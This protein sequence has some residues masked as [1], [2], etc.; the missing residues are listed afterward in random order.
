MAP[1]S[2]GSRAG[3]FFPLAL[4]FPVPV[5]SHFF[6]A[7]SH[8][9]GS[10]IPPLPRFSHYFIPVFEVFLLKSVIHYEVFFLVYFDPKE[11]LSESCTF[12]I[13]PAHPGLMPPSTFPGHCW[14]PPWIAKIP[15][16]DGKFSWFGKT[17][18]E[19]EVGGL[20]S[21][22]FGLFLLG[23]P[24]EI[25]EDDASQ[26]EHR[27][28]VVFGASGHQIHRISPQKSPFFSDGWGKTGGPWQGQRGPEEFQRVGCGP[29]G[30]ELIP[31]PFPGRIP[32]IPVVF[33]Q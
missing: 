16:L 20:K 21:A 14:D 22:A 15:F 12:A 26:P 2:C 32:G 10:R 28:G 4:L 25:S 8:F 13:F 11:N 29:G 30:G 23:I 7:Q 31:Q 3:S 27:G 9:P 1:K 5:S 17:T 33:N 24:W 18:A 19:F 6:P